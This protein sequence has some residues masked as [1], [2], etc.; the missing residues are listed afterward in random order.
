MRLLPAPLLR[1]PIGFLLLPQFAVIALASAIEPLRIANRYLR[2]HYRWSL[3]SLQGDPVMDDNGIPIAPHAALAESGPLGTL[4]VCADIKPERY[5]SRSLRQQLHALDRQ[6][7]T[8][9]AMDTGAFILARAGLL[10]RCRVTAHWEVIEAF[11]ERFPRI[12]VAQSLFEVGPSRMTCAGGTAALDMML[13]AMASDHGTT[14]ANRVAEHCL[15]DRIR[16]GDAPQRMALPL[17]TRIHHPRLAQ[18]VQHLESLHERSVS[19]D[20]LAHLCG[21][22]VRQLLRLFRE[23]LGEGPAHYHRRLRLDHARTL[24]RNNPMTVTE[25]ALASGFE[26]VAH[27]CRAYRIAHGHSPGEDRRSDYPPHPLQRDRLA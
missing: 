10:D 3:L 16:S 27:F 15:H 8:L 13:S 22:S 26:S 11:R 24:L 19:N 5:Y 1:N 7:A 6:G 12:A 23:H 25:V 4:I 21:L 20:E 18:A 17:R 2:N 9:G 14:L